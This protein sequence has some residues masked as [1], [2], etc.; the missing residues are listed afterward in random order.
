MVYKIAYCFLLYDRIVHENIWNDYF[1]NNSNH[2]IYTHVK[3]INDNTQK[4]VIDNKIETIDTKWC[5]MSLVYAYINL[6]K[7]AL[8]NKDNKYF[9][10]LSGECI[11]LNSYKDTHEKITNNKKST[12]HFWKRKS[13]HYKASQWMILNRKNAKALTKIDKNFIDEYENE[14]NDCPDEYYPI[15]W[16]I[17]Y[18]DKKFKNEIENKVTTY[19]TWYNKN[20]NGPKKLTYPEMLKY[21]NDICDSGAL[22]ARKFNKKAARNLYLKC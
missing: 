20:A 4:L 16:F 8:E 14:F 2:N 12:I 18:Y 22:F 3:T 6:L 5:D 9:V 13:G 15:N 21:K 10:F 17:H 7:K 11:P 1:G 19:V